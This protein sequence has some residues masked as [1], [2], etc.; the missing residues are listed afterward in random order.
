MF[1]V[2]GGEC[3]TRR[4]DLIVDKEEESLL[5]AEVDSLPDEE[6][7]LANSQVRGNQVFLLVQVTDPCLGSFLHND[8]EETE[9]DN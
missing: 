6:V 5:R 4:G 2:D 3:C 8:L 1:L 7:E 9:H